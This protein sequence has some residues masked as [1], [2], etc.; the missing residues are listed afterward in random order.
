MSANEDP[1]TNTEVVFV[2][3]PTGHLG[4]EHFELR[5]GPIPD[6]GENDVLVR[7]IYS[8]VEPYLRVLM[9]KDTPYSTKFDLDTVLP[10]RVVGEVVKS[11][12]P[13]HSEGDFVYGMLNWEEYSL[14]VGSE[15]LRRVDPTQAPL[16]AYVGVL[17]PS[18]LTAYVGMLE[19]GDPQAGETVYV[20]AAAGAVGQLAGQLAKMRGARVVGSVGSDEKVAYVT[21]GLGF[22]SAFNYKQAPDLTGA[23]REA[24]PDGIDL[25]FE[26]VGGANLDAVLDCINMDARI[27][28]CGTVSQYNS[29]TPRAV[30]NLMPLIVK[31]GRIL[32]FS[33][34]HHEHRLPDYIAEMSAWLRDGRIT[35]REHITKGIEN[36]PAA[37][38]GM[39]RGENIG[40]QILQI[41]EDTSRS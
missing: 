34:R 25:D 41:G 35:Y 33:V 7:N 36:G 37:L 21:Q 10:A 30:G 20:S 17:G 27:V 14:A 15:G 1:R 5:Q 28:L 3:R 40:K 38:V 31:R 12:H 6:V 8:S 18:G 26:N 4:E 32:G 13:D 16:S 19:V 39:M 22:D 11:R 24:C 23:L 2:A 29:E 9:T